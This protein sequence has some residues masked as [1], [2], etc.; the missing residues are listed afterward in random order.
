MSR[1]ALTAIVLVVAVTAGCGGGGS[2]ERA[3]ERT[4]VSKAVYGQ[5]IDALGLDVLAWFK[6]LSQIFFYASDLNEAGR[7]EAADHI[8][9]IQ[10]R[11]QEQ[12]DWLDGVVPPENVKVENAE[13]VDAL[14]DYSGELDGFKKDMGT[15]STGFGRAGERLGDAG[16]DFAKLGYAPWFSSEA[17]SELPCPRQ[18]TYSWP[19]GPWCTDPH[20]E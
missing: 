6:D 5:R 9:L 10:N 8:E 2:S 19:R 11:I 20:L 15:P 13:L 3:I 7:G 16:E 12:A 1:I 4:P 17:E 18:A 14:R